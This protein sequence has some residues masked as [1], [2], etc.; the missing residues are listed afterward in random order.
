MKK[1]SLLTSI[2][3]TVLLT[4]CG[5][6]SDGD[7]ADTAH[8]NNA[9]TP[10]KGTDKISS[11]VNKNGAAVSISQN[12]QLS[13]IDDK[14]TV[15][16]DGKKYKID[17]FD[18]YSLDDGLQYAIHGYLYTKNVG[19]YLV[20]QGKVTA[21]DKVPQTGEISYVGESRYVAKDFDGVRKGGSEFIVD[22]TKKTIVG[23]VRGNGYTVPLSGAIK[24]NAFEGESDKKVKMQGN[25]F[26]PKA[27]ELAGVYVDASKEFGGTFGGSQKPT[28]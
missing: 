28:K 23:N 9:S 17:D 26:G 16:I 7:L 12:T 2:L 8:S 15:E 14:N 1:V 18:G 3:A 20:A 25:F 27:E 21:E 11:K 13:P 19:D 24:G 5:G 22:F 10:S 6:G 4:A